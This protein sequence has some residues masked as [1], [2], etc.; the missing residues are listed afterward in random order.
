MLCTMTTSVK[1]FSIWSLRSEYLML[2]SI[3]SLDQSLICKNALQMI[4]E[5]AFLPQNKDWRFRHK[6]SQLM[7]QSLRSSNCQQK[8]MIMVK[9]LLPWS[10]YLHLLEKATCHTSRVTCFPTVYLVKAVKSPKKR[11]I[12]LK[13]NRQPSQKNFASRST[14]STILETSLR[15]LDTQEL[16]KRCKQSFSLVSNLQIWT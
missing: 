13:R 8:V 11:I 1:Y 3:C 15:S 4:L 2:I 12:L 10:P 7:C 6:A 16:K 9:N 14:Q 5:V